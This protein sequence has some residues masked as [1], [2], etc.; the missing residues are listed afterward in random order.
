MRQLIPYITKNV[1]VQITDG[2]DGI[3]CNTKE[4]IVENKALIVYKK[5][6]DCSAFDF[7]MVPL[8]GI[9]PARS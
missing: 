8:A 2:N 5:N 7:F 6:A 1:F 3:R 9:E 4:V